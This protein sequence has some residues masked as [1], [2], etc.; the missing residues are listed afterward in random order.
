MPSKWCI[1]SIS[2]DCHCRIRTRTHRMCNAC[3]V[4]HYKKKTIFI[5]RPHNDDWSGQQKWLHVA[6]FPV[7]PS[8]IHSNLMNANNNDSQLFLQPVNCVLMCFM[9]CLPPSLH[10]KRRRFCRYDQPSQLT[11]TCTCN[12]T[13]R[14]C[15]RTHLHVQLTCNV[16]RAH[17]HLTMCIIPFAFCIL[18]I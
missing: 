3:A 8:T 7:D 4:V 9:H 17:S 18:T 15:H 12:C 10:I 6:A 14:E 11:C 1:K 5:E 16:H 13:M 2:F